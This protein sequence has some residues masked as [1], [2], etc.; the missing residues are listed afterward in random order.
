MG[1]FDIEKEYR[2]MIEYYEYAHKRPYYFA[3]SCTTIQT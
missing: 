2:K 1:F 3:D